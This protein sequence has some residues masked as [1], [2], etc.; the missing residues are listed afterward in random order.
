MTQLL[1]ISSGK[2]RNGVVNVFIDM[3]DVLLDDEQ[4]EHE[5]PWDTEMVNL[6]SSKIGPT[7]THGKLLNI[8]ERALLRYCDPVLSDEESIYYHGTPPSRPNGSHIYTHGK[9]HDIINQTGNLEQSLSDDE[10]QDVQ[11][12]SAYLTPALPDD[13]DSGYTSGEF[14]N[15]DM[16]VFLRHDIR[17]QV[18][19]W[20]EHIPDTHCSE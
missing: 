6:N 19:D 10:W 17:V 4:S 1:G 13:D 9:H 8:D 3:C 12:Q 7:T 11:T 18:A 14:L 2:L 16:R 5:N 15:N 20:G